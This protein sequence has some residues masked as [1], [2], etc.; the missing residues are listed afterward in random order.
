MRFLMTLVRPRFL[1]PSTWSFVQLPLK[2]DDKVK[3]TVW[4]INP[5]GKD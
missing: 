4:E 2:E 5:H 1:M 3:T